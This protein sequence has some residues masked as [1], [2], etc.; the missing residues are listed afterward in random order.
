[1]GALTAGMNIP[2]DIVKGTGPIIMNPIRSM[3]DIRAITRLDPD[4][5]VPF[6][7][8]SPRGPR[9]GGLERLPRGGVRVLDSGL[10]V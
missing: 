3:E 4:K 6:V 2:F 9:P 10:R 5:S 7:G 1:M 8:Q